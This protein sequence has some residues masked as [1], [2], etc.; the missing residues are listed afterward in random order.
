[1]LVPPINGRKWGYWPY[2]LIGRTQQKTIVHMT[3]FGRKQNFFSLNV[4]TLEQYLYNCIEIRIH[5]NFDTRVFRKGNEI[6]KVERHGL[7]CYLY[8]AESRHVTGTVISVT[9]VDDVASQDAWKV[10]ET[11]S[12]VDEDNDDLTDDESDDEDDEDD[13]IEDAKHQAETDDVTA[14]GQEETNGDGPPSP[15]KRKT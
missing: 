7:S 4:C 9:S 12:D 8:F 15:K 14:M 1:M 5:G 13:S 3:F 10:R 11:T 2:L 6:Q